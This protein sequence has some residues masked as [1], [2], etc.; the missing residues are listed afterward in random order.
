VDRNDESRR[1]KAKESLSKLLATTAGTMLAASAIA[2]AR[3]AAAATSP[4]GDA[5]IYE[6]A[7]ELRAKLAAPAAESTGDEAPM[8]L[9]WWGNWHN[10]G[11]HPWW[12]NWPNWRNWHNWG[13]W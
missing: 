9:A 12:H 2:P 7:A 4:A 1:R 11:W 3:P 6:R 13:N 5:P 8:Q 10:G